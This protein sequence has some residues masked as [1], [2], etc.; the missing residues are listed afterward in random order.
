M[1]EHGHIWCNFVII[2]FFISSSDRGKLKT[3]LN[4][5]ETVLRGFFKLNKSGVIS[6]P[7]IYVLG[8]KVKKAFS[9]SDNFELAKWLDGS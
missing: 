7:R 1:H 8:L 2:K 4:P 9:Q 6:A 5:G 3:Q